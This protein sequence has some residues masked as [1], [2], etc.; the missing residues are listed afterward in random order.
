MICCFSK[1][2][3]LVSYVA[4]MEATAETVDASTSYGSWFSWYGRSSSDVPITSQPATVDSS[5][6]VAGS[7]WY[8]TLSSITSY[9]RWT[10]QA[11][12]TVEVTTTEVDDTKEVL[13]HEPPKRKIN[14]AI[15]G[16][17]DTLDSF[18]GAVIKIFIA[19]IYVGSN[20]QIVCKNEEKV[21]RIKNR[22]ASRPKS[23][24]S[25]TFSSIGNLAVEMAKRRM[26][27]KL[28]EAD[29][30]AELR[31]ER[32]LQE[33][34]FLNRKRHINK[35]M[36]M[37]A[38]NLAEI[39]RKQQGNKSNLMEELKRQSQQKRLK[40][41]ESGPSETTNTISQSTPKKQGKKS[42]LKRKLAKLGKGDM[43]SGNLFAELKKKIDSRKK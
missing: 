14:S 17:I 2:F 26:G 22:L 10:S 28:E 42:G 27:K 20:S 31:I 6:A 16:R 5:A 3:L 38:R 25:I 19:L 32:I 18:F 7:S 1:A 34:N 24:D 13:K 43:D 41:S 21:E 11:P 29:A 15:K 40:G 23:D 39:Q 35:E 4:A 30:N 8:D 36:E 33:T 12:T 37:I 9:V